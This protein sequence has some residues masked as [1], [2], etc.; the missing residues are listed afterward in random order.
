MFQR[1]E[2]IGWNELLDEYFLSHMLRPAT[3][4]SYNKVKQVFVNFMGETVL[5]EEVTRR[6]VLRWRRYILGE[7]KQSVHSWNNKV[8]HLRAIFNFAM[9]RKLLPHTQ[10]PFNSVAIKKMS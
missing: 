2:K 7:K 3:E 6:D 10:N 9:E 1:A 8:A 4:K 5:P